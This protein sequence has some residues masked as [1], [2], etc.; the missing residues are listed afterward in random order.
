MSRG[1][2]TPKQIV[3]LIES[4]GGDTEMVDGFEELDDEYQKKIEYAL[5]HGHVHDEDWNGVS[6]PKRNCPN[7]QSPADR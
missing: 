1:C 5:A 3:N 7:L 4:S 6:S 2:V